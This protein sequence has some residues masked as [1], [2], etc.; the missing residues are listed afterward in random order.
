MG[1]DS[2]LALLKSGVTEVTRVQA[3]TGAA[4]ACNPRKYLGVTG[5]TKVTDE[6]QTVTRVTPADQSGVTAKPAPVLACTL[7]TP[8]TPKIIKDEIGADAMARTSRWWLIHYPDCDPVKVYCCPEVSYAE[9][10]KWYPHAGPATPFIPT[11]RQASAPMSADEENAIRTW[12]ALIGEHDPTTI[13]EVIGQCQRDADPRDYFKERAADSLPKIRSDAGFDDDRRTCNQCTN[14]IARR[15]H[16]AI[17]G[18]IAASRI[19]E[20]MS[21]LPQRC[22]GYAPGEDDTDRRRGW[23]RWPGLIRLANLK[24]DVRF[25]HCRS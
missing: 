12:L 19:Y 16:A 9:I 15:C 20:P 1:F 18:E 3:S 6:I 22:E 7:V 17:R 13:T 8:V 23:E 5:V 4:F 24:P 2:L 21:D 10:L 14:L 11:I 25:S